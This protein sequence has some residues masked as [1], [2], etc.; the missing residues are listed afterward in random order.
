ME[1]LFP[2]KPVDNLQDNGRGTIRIEHLRC[3]LLHHRVNY[4][5]SNGDSGPLVIRND[6]E[7]LKIEYVKG[8]IGDG[9]LLQQRLA[10]YCH[11]D[12]LDLLEEREE[13]SH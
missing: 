10:Q 8:V 3:R 9:Y 4:L 5:Q 6:S 7:E 12:G 11:W 13:V 2:A 1:G